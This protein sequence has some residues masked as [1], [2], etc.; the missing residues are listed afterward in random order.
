M[1]PTR[2]IMLVFFLQPLAFGSWLPRIPDIQQRLGLGPADLALALLG[3][4]VGI[5]LTLPIA[6]PLVARIG[7]RSAIFYGFLGYLAV[8]SLPGFSNH[9]G[10]LFGALLLIGIA[11]SSL[12]LGLN[13]TADEIE[14]ASGKAIMSTCHGCW[15]LGMTVGS[16][17]GVGLAALGLAPQW[18]IMLVAVL[19]LPVAVLVI[20]ALPVGPAPE[21]VAAGGK[22]GSL[23]VPGLLL[24]GIC[25]FAF[26]STLVEGAAADWSAV[27]LKQA[28]S[29]D[30]A[31]AGIGYSA[32]AATTA[33]GRFAGDWM[34]TKWGPVAVARACVLAAL[35]GVTL[36]VLS[37]A[38]P[39][40]LIGFA[41]AGF[42]VSVG[43]P[44]AVTAAA[45]VGGRP[46]AAN[47]AMLS[48]VALLGFLLGP[49]LIGFIAQ[50]SSLRVGLVVLLPGLVASFVL[51][52]T[53][54]PRRPAIAAEPQGLTALPIGNG[55]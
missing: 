29:A 48:I 42:G 22:T 1:R 51:A 24:L 44:L 13:I 49:P 40:S 21:P 19:V 3:L 54:R 18:S 47:V 32:F 36:I 53:L 6:G 7:G 5:L 4:P 20:R 28:F 15:S 39:M 46:A 52:A 11:M 23:F 12:E 31:A 55:K 26:G 14:K 43:F 50:H 41:L 30:S 16:L 37:P 9:I 34:K 38:Y 25:V 17:L 27:Y 8:V 33:A 45:G 10:V 2:L 35:I